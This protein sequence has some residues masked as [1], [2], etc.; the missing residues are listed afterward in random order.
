MKVTA[1]ARGYFGS[2]REV[3]ETFDVPDGAKASW[4][5]PKAQIEADAKAAAAKALT[6]AAEKA[7]ADADNA[8]RDADEA[9]KAAKAAE[10]ANL[11][12]PKVNGKDGGDLV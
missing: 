6:A 3:G 4:F 8:A 2:Y 12:K 7:K 5:K 10:V 9:E 1:T 11:F